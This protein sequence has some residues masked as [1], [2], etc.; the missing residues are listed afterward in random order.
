MENYSEKILKKNHSSI[1]KKSVAN[2]DNLQAWK[3]KWNVVCQLSVQMGDGKS[4]MSASWSWQRIMYYLLFLKINT[5]V[6]LT[7]QLEIG[8]E[9]NTINI[10]LY[11]INW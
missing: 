6:I 9:F 5:N 2:K 4:K 8:V 3:L 11:F 7:K 10:T 1:C